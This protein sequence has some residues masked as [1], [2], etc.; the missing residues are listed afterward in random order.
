MVRVKQNLEP[1]LKET[2]MKLIIA[3]STILA[4]L[5]GTASIARAEVHERPDL[6]VAPIITQPTAE[7]TARAILN[8]KDLS[9][10]NLKPGDMM[11]KTVYP[12]KGYVKP[13]G[14]DN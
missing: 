12:T 5:A 1:K 7:V 14:G 2:I 13:K 8:T 10:W 11:I 4:L 3:T 6:Y 9:R